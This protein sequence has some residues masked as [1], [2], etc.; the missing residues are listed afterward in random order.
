VQSLDDGAHRVRKVLFT[1]LLTPEA[2]RRIA[3]LAAAE[4]RRR[5]VLWE[6]AGGSVVLHDQAREIHCVAI[7]AWA[8]VPLPGGGAGKLAARLG[9]LV[10]TPAALGPGY[11]KGRLARWRAER[12][13]GRLVDEARRG[14]RAARTGSALLA[15][16]EHRDHD[17]ALLDGR[18]AAVELLNIL[19]PVVAVARFTVFAA[20]ALHEHPEWRD[21]LRTGDP[22]G[23]GAFVQE[24][25]RHYPFFPAV[26]ARVR[27][28]FEWQG[29]RFPAGR[30]VLLDLYGTDHDPRLWDRPDEFRPDR[31]RGRDIEAFELIPQ[32]G[33]D[34]ERG[35]RCPGEWTTIELLKVAVQVLA[36]ELDYS[37]PDQDLRVRLDDMPALPASGFVVTGVRTSATKATR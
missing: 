33:G 7:C 18:T 27:D 10:D 35:H 37:V 1:A 13:A 14:T 23:I 26:P 6:G 34:L 30:P 19:R 22:A 9:A 16:A 12:W 21:R 11:L 5:A 24:V 17:G 29:H 31:F 8:G 32:G 36:V 28:D 3:D 20:L 2:A 15:V 4:W 25:R